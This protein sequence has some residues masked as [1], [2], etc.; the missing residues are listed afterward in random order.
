MTISEQMRPLLP[1]HYYILYEP[2][3]DRG[4][5]TLLFISQR[6]LVKVKGTM[7]REFKQG[8]LPLLDG[9][10]TLAE[11]QS[12]VAGILPPGNVNVALALLEEQNLL[13]ADVPSRENVPGRLAPQLN[14]F[15][16]LGLASHQAQ[17]RLARAKVSVVGL[18][19]VGSLV[20]TGLAAAG[21]GQLRLID[22]LPVREADGLYSPV[23][24]AAD[25]G[26][27][28]ARAVQGAIE[29]RFSSIS[30]NSVESRIETD[31]Q[32]A[33]AL[34]GPDFVV[35]CVDSGQS[36]YCYKLNRACNASRIPW[37]TC[38][39]AGFE[40]IVGPTIRSGE[41]ACYLCYTMRAVAS[42][43]DPEQD[44]NFQQFLDSHRTDDA[45][46]RENLGFSAGLVASLAGMEILKS[47][48]KLGSCQTDGAIL[49]VDFL[50][51]SVRRHVVLR[52]PRCPVCFPPAPRER[53]AA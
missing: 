40:G 37:M 17:E 2:P 43:R 49:V 21:V 27:N 36:V 5:E 53:P 19:G 10:H 42:A 1:S 35:C 3:D 23:Y 38:V 6:R 11:I 46:R 16:E 28:R 34:D 8:V 7:L 4:D 22:D 9:R 32:M 26:N 13:I 20:A 15:H 33:T 45:D 25:L 52:N 18:G 50:Q 30:V 39:A 24:S 14:F 31:E 48:A 29:G 41:T 47:L 12:S 44:F 51:A